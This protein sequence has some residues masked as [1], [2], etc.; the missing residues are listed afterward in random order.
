ME[1]HPVQC[2]SHSRPVHVSSQLFWVSEF[3]SC[4]DAKF[5]LWLNLSLD[6]GSTLSIAK[7]VQVQNLVQSSILKE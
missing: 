5:H 4:R 1:A 6:A 3:I 2:I 7:E